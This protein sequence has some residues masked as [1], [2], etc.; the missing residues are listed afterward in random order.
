MQAASFGGRSECTSLPSDAGHVKETPY[1]RLTRASCCAMDLPGHVA[2]LRGRKLNVDGRYLRWLPGP[3]HRYLLTKLL[4][5][6][7]CLSA[8]DLK[9]RPKRS[10][11]DRNDADAP[12]AN[13]A[14]GSS[15]RLAPVPAGPA[16]DAVEIGLS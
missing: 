6:L 16:L 1:L 3:P 14:R 4:D 5:I 15:A 10:R 9:C 7:C 13:L 8:A 2:R 11:G 12:R